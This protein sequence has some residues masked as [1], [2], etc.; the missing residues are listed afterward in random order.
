MTKA[1]MCIACN[2]LLPLN[3]VECKC[4][5]QEYIEVILDY[6]EDTDVGKD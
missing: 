4:G 6:V 2:R 3:V 5:G 1:K